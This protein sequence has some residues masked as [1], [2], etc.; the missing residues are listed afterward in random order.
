MKWILDAVEKK[1]SGGGKGGLAKKIADEIV[2]VAEGRS[3]VWERR[4]QV[5]KQGVSAR[6]NVKWTQ[7]KR[8]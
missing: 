2:A 5:H 6:A 8:K 1:P 3:S 7:M 4:A